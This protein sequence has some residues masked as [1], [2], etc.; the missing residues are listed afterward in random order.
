MRT[1][2]NSK[3][4]NTDSANF[5]WQYDFVFP[6]VKF[7]GRAVDGALVDKANNVSK[8]ENTSLECPGWT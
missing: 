4:E 2:S 3:T 7:S 1:G 5:C 8:N 6:G